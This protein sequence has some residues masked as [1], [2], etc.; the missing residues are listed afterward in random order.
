MKADWIAV[1]WGTTNLRAF[2]MGP[3]GLRAE[4]MSEDGM[5]RLTPAEFEPALI[6]L[7]EPWLGQGVTPVLAC[8]M[9]GSRQGWQEAPYRSVPCAP[10]EPGQLVPVPVRDGRIRVEIAPG[11]K[12]MRPAD[13]MRGEETQIAG[14]LALHPGFDGAMCLPGTH[15]KWVQ[16]S[17]GEV[18]SFQTFLTG[19]MFALFSTQSVLRHGMAGTGWDEAAFDAGVAEGMARPERLAASLFRLRA[20]GLIAD[21][22]ADAARARLSGLLIGAELAASRAYWLGAR[23]V[24]VGSAALTGLYARAL[25][26]QAVTVETLAAKD[27]TIAGLAYAAGAL[28]KPVSKAAE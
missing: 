10:L 27:C 19:E 22:G 3:E 15:S 12:Q 9:V 16:I 14:A 13:V 23:V 21:L 25:A 7:I 28:S 24:L 5:G 6:R 20:E 2:A 4:V 26:A 1:D 11:L 18:V 17:A 8:G